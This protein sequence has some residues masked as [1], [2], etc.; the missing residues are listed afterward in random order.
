V[1]LNP[2]D[3]ETLSATLAK[4][5]T[6]SGVL[7]GSFLSGGDITITDST[8]LGI[9]KITVD[10]AKSTD[11]KLEFTMTLSKALPT[12]QTKLTFQVSKKN[13]DGN[14][15]QSPKFDLTLNPPPAAPAAPA[16]TTPATEKPPAAPAAPH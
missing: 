2:T 16:T 3:G 8:T 11:K 15:I 9:S 12:T 6:I 1:D 4:A 14:T 13:S 5:G 10:T 7:E